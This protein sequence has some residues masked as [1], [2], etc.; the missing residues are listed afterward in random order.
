MRNSILI[1]LLTRFIKSTI[2]MNYIFIFCLGL[3]SLGALAD[4]TLASKQQIGMFKN[5][6]TCVVLE[7]GISSF[8]MYIKDAVQKYWKSTEFEF[9]DQKEFEKRRYNTKYSFL[10]KIQVA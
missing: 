10:I 3:F 1:R 5:S 8:N 2:F 7:D 6:K 4:T 9:I